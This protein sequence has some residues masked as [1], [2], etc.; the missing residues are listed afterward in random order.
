MSSDPRPTPPRPTPPRYDESPLTRARRVI[1]LEL[2]GTPFTPADAAWLHH[3]PL[4]WLRALV[5]ARRDI[6]Q[7]VH[8]GRA[9][10]DAFRPAPGGP[11]SPMYVKASQRHQ[12]LSKD[13]TRISHQLVQRIE[14]VKA[15]I[16]PEPVV[17]YL[18]WGDM[19]NLMLE[20]AEKAL[21]GDTATVAEQALWWADRFTEQDIYDTRAERDAAL[22]EHRRRMPA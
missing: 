10:L 16:G 13:Y 6:D 14:Q 20:L 17:G 2:K 5:A 3:N 21:A 12:E 11:P 9:I 18:N 1:E 4:M 22:A 8:E 15:I 19:V 7:Q